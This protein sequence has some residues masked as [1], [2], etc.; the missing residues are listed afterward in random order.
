ML[1]GSQKLSF[2]QK[3]RLSLP[4]T[5]RRKINEETQGHSLYIVPGRRP[6]TLAI[7]PEKVYEQTLSG[8]P[9]DEELSEGTY[10]YREF[11]S[12]HTLLVD[13]DDQGRVLVPQW[14]LDSADIGKDVTLVGM[15]NHLVLWRRDEHETF[16]RQ[17]WQNVGQR[18]AAAREEMRKLAGRKA[19]AEDS[20][21][22]SAG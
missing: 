19:A 5:F 9:D 10:E 12:A 6:R 1:L 18:R 22:A 3:N 21:E 2:D 15:R 8:E 4:Y 16:T 17:M 14:L 11:Q 13:P 7:Y 20:S